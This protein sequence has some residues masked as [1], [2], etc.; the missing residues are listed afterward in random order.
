MNDLIFYFLLC[1]AFGEI[2]KLKPFYIVNELLISRSLTSCMFV[3]GRH[4][5]LEFFLRHLSVLIFVHLANGLLDD[6][7]TYHEF[8]FQSVQHKTDSIIEFGWVKASRFILVVVFEELADCG[9][10]YMIL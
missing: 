10:E 2:I 4:N 7:L 5:S 8:Q 6:T 9:V 1:S 3:D